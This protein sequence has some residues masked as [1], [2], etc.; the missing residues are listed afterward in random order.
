MTIKYLLRQTLLGTT[1][2]GNIDIGKAYF[3][4]QWVNKVVK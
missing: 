2:W 4:S 3:P 1:L